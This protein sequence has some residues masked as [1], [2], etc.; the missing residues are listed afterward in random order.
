MELNSSPVSRCLDTKLLILG[1]E[2]PDLLAIFLLL[3]VLNFMF[4]SIG[5]V[6]SLIV[7]ALPLGLAVLLRYGKRGKPDNY[8]LH[9]ARFWFAP[10]VYSA[11]AEPQVF[12]LPPRLKG[13][14]SI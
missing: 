6:T 5:G 1:F 4:G 13:F 10:G 14:R 7:W 2:I 12:M 8:L 11:F 9:L 3:A